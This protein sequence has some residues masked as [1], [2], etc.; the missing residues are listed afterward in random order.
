MSTV[1][2]KP[3]RKRKVAD[4]AILPLSL[5]KL[6][7]GSG[8][9]GRM[10]QHEKE[11]DEEWNFDEKV[12][13]DGKN[14]YELDFEDED[15]D[16]DDDEDGDSVSSNVTIDETSDTSLLTIVPAVTP[17]TPV[18]PGSPS[19]PVSRCVVDLALE[20]TPELLR[21]TKRKPPADCHV[22]IRWSELH[23]LVKDNFACA[24][25][26]KR[27]VDFNRTTVGIATE[28]HFHCQGCKLN[29]TAEAM[30]SNYCEKKMIRTLFAEKDG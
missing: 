19:T 26:G 29:G 10:F 5:R 9:G 28:L 14:D 20:H 6:L 27:V 11:D 3:N 23:K 1:T 22:L 18:T 17:V 8:H 12:D 2:P 16:D 24:N 13:G 15:D 7:Y 25:C 4:P 30:R 21:Q